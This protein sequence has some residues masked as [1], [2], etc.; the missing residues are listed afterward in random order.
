[1]GGTVVFALCYHFLP[2]GPGE[3]LRRGTSPPPGSP[4]EVFPIYPE[5][6]PLSDTSSTATPNPSG[7][8]VK[9][10]PPIS[11]DGANAIR[12]EETLNRFLTA[13]SLDERLELIDPLL[14]AEQ[15]QDTILSR[16]L[17]DVIGVTPETPS[18]DPIEKISNFPFR[19]SFQGGEGSISEYTILVRYRADLPPKIVI[20]PFLDLVGG[21]LARFAATPT[22][23]AQTFRAV[24]E[25]MPRCFEENIPSPDKK[26]TYKL[27]ACDVGRATA[28][29]YASRYSSLAEDLFTPDSKIRWGK[30]V[31]AT[32]TLEW[33]TTEDPTQ[34][35]IE[36]LEI[37]GLDWNS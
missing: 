14:P 26:F 37:K 7:Q 35:Y 4:P 10:A 6:K 13:S 16:P 17:P 33:N 30:R 8:V 9:D 34:P 28:R 3:S 23:G 12:A 21:R 27:T 25:A 24:I 29:A 11:A 22:S 18:F 31:R 5:D 20:E 36:L 2:G 15:L 32:I 19:V 1:L